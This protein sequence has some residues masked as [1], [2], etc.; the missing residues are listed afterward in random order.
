ME[1]RDPLPVWRQLIDIIAAIVSRNGV[2][3]TATMLFEVDL[4]QITAVGLYESIDFVR[5]FA[6]IESITTLVSNQTQSPCEGRVLKDIALGTDIL[7]TNGAGLVTD[8]KVIRTQVLDQT[9]VNLETLS[10]PPV[11]YRPGLNI[12]TCADNN[13]TGKRLV[14]NAVLYE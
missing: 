10:D 11:H 7:V 5:D 9:K 8:Y 1:R 4:A 3:P 14:V 12:A 13:E 2:N 6:L